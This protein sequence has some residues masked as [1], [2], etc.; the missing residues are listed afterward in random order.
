MTMIPAFSSAF[1]KI[2]RNFTKTETGVQIDFQRELRNGQTI[3][4][5]TTITN[6]EDGGATVNVNHTGRN[7]QTKTLE[8]TY[9]PE[10]VAAFKEQLGALGQKLA[11]NPVTLPGG[12]VLD[13]SA[14]LNISA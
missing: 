4:R 1:H 2:E 7:G 12:K 13:G 10:Q 3:S 9:T 5:Q 11:D 14:L 6:N 8:K